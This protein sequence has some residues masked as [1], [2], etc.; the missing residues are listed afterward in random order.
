MD[1]LDDM[2]VSVIC[3]LMSRNL[4]SSRPE[5]DSQVVNRFRESYLNWCASRDFSQ[6]S[7]LEE[8]DWLIRFVLRTRNAPLRLI[9]TGGCNQYVR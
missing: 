2:M 1:Q 9:S 6:W 8:R 7:I 3:I 4:M 5:Y